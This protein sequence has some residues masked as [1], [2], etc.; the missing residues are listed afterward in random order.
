[1]TN[2][3]IIFVTGATGNQGGAVARN[4]LKQ[5]FTVKALT[6]D[7]H[8]D[9]ALNLKKLNI[10]VVKGDLNDAGTYLGYL[11]DVYGV[12]SVQT[13]ENGV[14]KEIRQGITLATL[15]KESGVK[16]FLYSSVAAAHLNTGVPHMDSK[17]KI[18]NHTRQA[19]LP[20]TIIRPVSLF[21][22]FLIPQ[23][24]KGILKGKLIQPVNKD[25]L[26]QYIAAEDIGKAATGIFQNS[27][28]WLGKTITLATEQLSAWEVADLFSTVLNKK[29][30]YRK[31]PALV[32]RIFLGKNVY[33][34]FKWMDEKSHFL[35]EDIES[36]RQEFPDLISL[37]SWIKMNF[38]SY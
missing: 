10:E 1:M 37:K 24:K 16:H 28:K 36:T 21:E 29:T 27:D 25:T 26:L 9:K 23:V 2:N 12:F 38:K 4:L 35:K 13:F 6:R 11:K 17:F 15:A 31:L 30:E 8:S 34:M 22:N 32:T 19:G 7:I 3:K 33:K 20:F 14:E 18:E 5:G